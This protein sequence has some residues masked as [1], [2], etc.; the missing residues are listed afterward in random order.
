MSWA[1]D[2]ERYQHQ[3]R[4]MCRTGPCPINPRTGPMS[5]IDPYRGSAGVSQ[6]AKFRARARPRHPAQRVPR[7]AAPARRARG[8]VS[9][10]AAND[11]PSG[12]RLGPFTG[13][14]RQP[15]RG[16][17]NRE[18]REHL[19]DTIQHQYSAAGRPT[20]GLHDPAATPTAGSARR[21]IIPTAD[22]EWP[23]ETRAMRPTPR[24]RPPR[25][26]HGHPAVGSR[27]RSRRPRRGQ[28]DG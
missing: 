5:E 13:G 9:C 17:N 2:L 23:L 16:E 26:L 1:D 8:R 25:P 20:D 6:Q 4:E 22:A 27:Q 12:A 11:S 10:R 21:R 7:P 15:P 19:F 14:L 28:L 24:L 3:R 18:G